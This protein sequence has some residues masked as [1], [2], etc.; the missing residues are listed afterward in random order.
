MKTIGEFVV[1][2][3]R[4]VVSGRRSDVEKHECNLSHAHRPITLVGGIQRIISM[5]LARTR[6]T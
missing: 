4:I 3:H 2:C 5:N 6:R 1:E